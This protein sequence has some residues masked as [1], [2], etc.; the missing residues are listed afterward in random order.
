VRLDVDIQKLIREMKRAV[1]EARLS[2]LLS[3]I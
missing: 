3:G 1:W 2:A